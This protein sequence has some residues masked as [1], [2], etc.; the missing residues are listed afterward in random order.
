VGPLGGGVR[1]LR[2]PT[3]NKKLLMAG[4]L[5]CGAGDPEALTINAKK[6]RRWVPGRWCR[7]FGSAHHQF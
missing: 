3:I 7:R 5:G 1:D 4:P 6:C 2:T